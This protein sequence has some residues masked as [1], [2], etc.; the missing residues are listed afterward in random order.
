[1]TEITTDNLPDAVKE[2][3]A[4]ET[5]DVLEFVEGQGTPADSVT[6]YTNNKA[7]FRLGQLIDQEAANGDRAQAEGLGIADELEWVDP[8]EIAAL[9]EQIEATALTFELSGLAPAAKEAIRKSL[10]AKHGFSDSKPLA[11]QEA[12]F[13]DYTHTLI[14]KTITGVTRA[15]GVRDPKTWDVERVAGLRARLNEAEFKRLDNAV[16]EINFKTDVFDRAVSA[17]FLSKR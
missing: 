6:I 10:T 7:G 12:Y 5:F 2:A 4:P 1:M 3:L 9:R 8:D 16:Y 15:D 13:E 14:A 17:D 11:E